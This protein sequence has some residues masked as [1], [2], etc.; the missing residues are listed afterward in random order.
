MITQG[1]MIRIL[2]CLIKAFLV[3]SRLASRTSN[4][5]ISWWSPTLATRTEFWWELLPEYSAQIVSRSF[6][7]RTQLRRASQRRHRSRWCRK[8]W[9]GVSWTSRANNSSPTS[10]PPRR[11]W[12]SGPRT[13]PRE[14]STTTSRWNILALTMLY[15]KPHLLSSK[16]PKVKVG[17]KHWHMWVKPQWWHQLS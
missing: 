7:T 3:V 8:P 13:S 10:C 9:S 1:Y 16:T 2:V 15:F 5:I 12:R 11:R 6:S 17:Y 14:R 4:T